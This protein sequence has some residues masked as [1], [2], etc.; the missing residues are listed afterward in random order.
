M[1]KLTKTTEFEGYISGDGECFCLDKRSQEEKGVQEQ[2]ILA[3]GNFDGQ[4]K[5][6]E[7][8][9]LYPNDFFPKE[10]APLMSDKRGKF[11]FKITVKAIPISI[12]NQDIKETKQNV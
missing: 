6:D 8:N 9:R 10:C 5:E 1:K 11:K 12:K 7:K 3:S 2:R 4:F